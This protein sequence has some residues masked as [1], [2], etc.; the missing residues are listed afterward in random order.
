[1]AVAVS[2]AT[3]VQLL[4]AITLL[5]QTIELTPEGSVDQNNRKH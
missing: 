1:M 5:S 3:P 2:M 4:H